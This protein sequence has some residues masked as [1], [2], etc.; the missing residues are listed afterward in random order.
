MDE[1]QLLKNNHT[2]TK[3]SQTRSNYGRDNK[4]L[5]KKFL[6]NSKKILKT[7]REKKSIPHNN[8]Q[9][10]EIVAK[11]EFPKNDLQAIFSGDSV[12]K[13]IKTRR[14]ELKVNDTIVALIS[15]CLILL[16]FYQV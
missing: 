13:N 4:N 14:K 6:S 11:K 10:L 3:I 9:V 7:Y 15:F 5:N 8:T 12:M 1:E 16:C 2:R